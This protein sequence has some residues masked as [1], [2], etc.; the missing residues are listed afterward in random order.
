[1]LTGDTILEAATFDI[2]PGKGAGFEAAIAQALPLLAATEGYVAHRLR[3]CVEDP[4][5]YLLLVEWRGLADHMDGFRNSPRFAQW[6]A[7]IGPYFAA[8]PLVQHHAP[9]TGV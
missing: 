6:R 2:L 5:R 8:P 7:L 4:D 1:M 3:R 9:V